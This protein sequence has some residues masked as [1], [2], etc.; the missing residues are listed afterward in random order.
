M[1]R[2]GTP[3]AEPKALLT[4]NLDGELQFNQSAAPLTSVKNQG[5]ERLGEVEF[6]EVPA[7]VAMGV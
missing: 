1:A 7:G 6:D 3:A 5:G 4:Q 2:P